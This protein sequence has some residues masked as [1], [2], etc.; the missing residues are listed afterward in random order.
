MIG[1]VG[2]LG[3][4]AGADL[5]LKLCHQ[6]L[7]TRDQDHLPVALLSLPGEVPDRTRFLT[8][9]VPLNPA[10][11]IARILHQLEVMGA[12]VAG[13][14]CN[15][16]HAPHIFDHVC[17]SLKGRQSR[18]RL[19][20][21]VEETVRFVSEELPTISRI[22]IL[23]TY[24][25][26]QA[27]VY[28]NAFSN[29][30][31]TV[32]TLDNAD[33]HDLVHRAIYDPQ[34]GLK[35]QPHPVSDEAARRLHLA[36]QRLESRGAQAVILGC[37]ELP[38]AFLQGTVGQMLAIDPALILARALIRHLRPDR[39]KPLPSPVY[40]GPEPQSMGYSV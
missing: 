28:P 27:G 38:F 17:A 37:T 12:T 10:V 33:I 4:H 32:I 8:G 40:R 9:Q 22:G 11:P 30:S 25:T 14:A 18:L 16:S 29:S 13:I 24:G 39:L 31:L 2:G 34:W 35:V 3:P 15:T 1:I 21:M 23:S 20:N 26:H 7:A 19:L 5:L 36:Q 6:T